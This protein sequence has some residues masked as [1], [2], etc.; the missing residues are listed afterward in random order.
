MAHQAHNIPWTL[1]SSNLHWATAH[2][3]TNLRPRMKPNQGKEITHFIEAFMRT[4][5]E[6]SATERK[7]Y[8]DTYDPTPPTEYILD[9]AVVK[10]ITP[11]VRKWRS[12][13]YGLQ[14]KCPS[15]VCQ[16]AHYKAECQCIP[17]PDEE[18]KAAAFVRP[19]GMRHC[20]EFFDDN[21]DAFFNIEVVKTLLL[22]GEIDAILRAC[23]L[24]GIS[25]KF[26]WQDSECQCEYPVLGWDQIC[27]KALRAY[28][29]LN[30][31]Y[32]F[33]NIWDEESGRSAEK[34]YRNSKF[35]QYTLRTCTGTGQTSE[36]SAY[37]H[38][39]FFGI[40][41]DQFRG[42]FWYPKIRKD[43][44]LRWT[45]EKTESYRRPIDHYGK[46][47]IDEFLTL[48]NESLPNHQP[49]KSDVT[50]VQDLLYRKGLP[51]ELVLDIMQLASY[52]PV[53]RLATP[54]DPF[55][56]SNRKELSQYLT[57]CWQVLVRCDMMAKALGM[58]MPW[59]ELVGNCIAEFW[60]DER[61]GQ[62]RFFWSPISEDG[63]RL[64]KVFVNPHV[65]SD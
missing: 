50:L 59:K 37:P 27:I 8:S 6:H 43:H 57:Y 31:I 17:I 52:K 51:A 9:D 62:G 38:R 5:N 30:T 3:V 20:Y 44:W 35:Y 4:I 63:D 49:G 7:K 39:Q 15:G 48:E 14:G 42:E 11:T 32:C 58:E 13:G 21:S 26:W 2:G 1:L 29:C 60:A 40:S 24:P 25:L 19:R 23:A 45:D 33:P 36:V 54:H 55:H 34:D 16:V 41:D 61:C 56:P 53:G 47:P 12:Y 10:K 18:R 46:V 28:I 64:P 65:Q 22:H